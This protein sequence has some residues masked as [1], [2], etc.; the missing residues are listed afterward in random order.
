MIFF[1]SPFAENRGREPEDE[2]EEFSTSEGFCSRPALPA[3]RRS[4]GRRYPERKRS[5]AKEYFGK[6]SLAKE[7]FGKHSLAKE[8]F[9]KHSLAKEYFG[10]LLGASYINTI[11]IV[12]I[13]QC[14]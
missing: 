8:Y 9:G 11:I 14:C 7:Y 1:L 10:K 13:D 5:L 3:G 12:L 2:C 4:V 6:H